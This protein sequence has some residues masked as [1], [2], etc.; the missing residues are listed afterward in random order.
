MRRPR[1][2]IRI[3]TCSSLPVR[4]ASRVPRKHFKNCVYIIDARMLLNNYMQGNPY[5]ID[6][7]S[8][9]RDGLSDPLWQATLFGA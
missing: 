1:D 7:V 4:F 3:I 9:A 8:V 5:N 2:R 6:Y